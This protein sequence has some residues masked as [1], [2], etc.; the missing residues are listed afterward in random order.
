MDKH[1]GFQGLATALLK[2]L[3]R[4][5]WQH[6][7]GGWRLQNA[8]RKISGLAPIRIQGYRTLYVNVVEDNWQ[9]NELL[10]GEPFAQIPHEERIRNLATRFVRPG[11]C[12]YDI[13]GNIGL[14][15]VLFERLAGDKGEVHVF[16]PIPDLFA[17]LSFTFRGS[18]VKVHNL[19]LSNANGIVDLYI[20]EDHSMSS[21]GNWR[22]SDRCIQ[23][24]TERLDAVS[25]LRAP[26]FIKID[27]EGAEPLVIQ[28]A[29]DTIRKSMPVIVFE[30]LRAATEVLGYRR[31]WVM[32]R[33]LEIEGYSA[34]Q[35]EENGSLA[36]VKEDRPECCEIVMVPRG[37]LSS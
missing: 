1:L 23:C 22:N 2:R 25:G 19:A 28:G 17:A 13:G 12:V 21:M 34:F 16:E 26:D 36:A 27:V 33:L 18:R 35:L 15:A 11:D 29:M 9:V 6:L 31:G 5:G 7:R 24:P 14:H 32:E 10:D 4:K 30:E 3:R 20:P 8:L 37:R